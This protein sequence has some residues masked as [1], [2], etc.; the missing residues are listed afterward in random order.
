MQVVMPRVNKNERLICRPT[1]TEEGLLSIAKTVEE[2]REEERC[3][4]GDLLRILLILMQL[5]ED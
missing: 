3:V 5:T 1:K 2:R 4:F